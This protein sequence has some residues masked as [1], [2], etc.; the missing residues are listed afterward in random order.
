MQSVRPGRPPVDGAT[1]FGPMVS[2]TLTAAATIPLSGPK[3]AS[4]LSISSIA[5]GMRP[6]R[7]SSSISMNRM[8]RSMGRS[9]RT[10]H[11][12]DSAR[13]S[14]APATPPWKATT[15]SRESGQLRRL[16]PGAHNRG[17]RERPRGAARG[18]TTP[19]RTRGLLRRP[20]GTTP[21]FAESSGPKL[22]L[23][24]KRHGVGPKRPFFQQ[25]ADHCL[26]QVCLAGFREAARSQKLREMPLA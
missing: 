5:S 26:R 17:T 10:R 16:L 3:S 9:A 19:A 12:A 2:R 18:R 20:S 21:R 22:R 7:S 1:C 15:I 6:C 23:T 8:R 25:P 13:G 24:L 4:A 14:S 11:N